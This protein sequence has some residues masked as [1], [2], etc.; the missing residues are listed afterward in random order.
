[1]TFSRAPPHT[2]ICVSSISSTVCVQHP[3]GFAGHQ[4]VFAPEACADFH[5]FARIQA[6][7]RACPHSGGVSKSGRVVPVESRAV[8]QERSELRGR[9]AKLPDT[10]FTRIELQTPDP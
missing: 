2:D 4:P 10:V 8:S 9:V 7:A 1:M 6:I 5:E 3:A